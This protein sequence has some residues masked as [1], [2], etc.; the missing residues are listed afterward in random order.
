[1][2]RQFSIIGVTVLPPRHEIG[3]KAEILANV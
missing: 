3:S 2:L 1:M